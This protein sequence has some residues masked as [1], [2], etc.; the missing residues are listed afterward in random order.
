[1]GQ[2][3]HS[4]GWDVRQVYA[5]NIK[6]AQALAKAFDA[7]AI[8]ELAEVEP[9]L[10]VIL[11]AV[12]DDAIKS[13]SDELPNTTALVLHCSGATPLNVINQVYRGVVW[14]LRSISQNQATNWKGL[15]VVVEADTDIA[16]VRCLD[17]VQDLGANAVQ[18]DGKE[19]STAHLVA[20]ILNNFSNHLLH[21]ADTLCDAQSMDRRI[22]QDLMAHTLTYKGKA[23]LSQTG[24]A[25][26][27]DH[28]I[29]EHQLKQLKAF[30]QFQEIY[31]AMSQSIMHTQNQHEL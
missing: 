17:F 10:N 14:P 18:M 21:M 31:S 11:I 12:S 20:V 5:R 2:Q 28:K 23:A 8:S 25:A 24:P 7:R 13:M 1:M 27:N 6:A 3:L 16:T 22:F 9:D 19:R 4:K 30:P 29:I 26:R 15:N